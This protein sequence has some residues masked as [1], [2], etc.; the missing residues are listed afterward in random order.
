MPGRGI[1]LMDHG[2]PALRGPH[3]GLQAPRRA[4]GALRVPN[5]D[6]SRP[7]SSPTV[8][9]ATG[10]SIREGVPLH[11]RSTGLSWGGT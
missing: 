4:G 1:K 8:F 2:G 9:P 5:P 10:G 6:S 3:G 11:A 7:E